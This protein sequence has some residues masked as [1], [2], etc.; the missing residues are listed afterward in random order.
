[1]TDGEAA[2]GT[3]TRTRAG[4]D[5]PR[6]DSTRR[7]ARPYALTAAEIPLLAAPATTGRGSSHPTRRGTTARQGTEAPASAGQTLVT[8]ARTASSGTKAP[9]TADSAG[10][11]TERQIC[12]TIAVNINA[13]SDETV[14]DSVA[15][16]IARTSAGSHHAATHTSRHSTANTTSPESAS[17]A[18]TADATGT[19]STSRPH[20]R[21]GS[22][23]GHAGSA[24]RLGLAHTRRIAR[25]PAA[26][27]CSTSTTA[28]APH[29]H[30]RHH[31]GTGPARALATL[32]IR[33][34]RGFTQIGIVND[35][36]GI[37]SHTPGATQGST[38]LHF[39]PGILG[40]GHC[41]LLRASTHIHENNRYELLPKTRPQPTLQ[42]VMGSRPQPSTVH[43]V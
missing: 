26:G 6:G 14:R 1:M 40:V 10:G 18:H 22:S 41:L 5:S 16:D 32:G 13:V 7:S 35:I 21:R 39:R 31:P 9:R 11:G 37:R 2:S 4:A 24:H 19:Q 36:I 38:S 23:A 3:G 25:H 33:V 15:V 29:H 12:H 34:D 30:G 28:A 17:R 8:T 20:R 27:R 43:P 42:G